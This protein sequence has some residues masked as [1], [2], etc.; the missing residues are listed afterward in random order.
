MKR[1]EVLWSLKL[2]T[3]RYEE[4]TVETVAEFNDI[5]IENAR[6]HLLNL[7]QKILYD[8]EK[9]VILTERCE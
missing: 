3:E 1:E 2:L 8:T 6:S 7:N 5:L 4:V 9:Q